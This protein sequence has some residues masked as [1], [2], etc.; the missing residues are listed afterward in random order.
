MEKKIPTALSVDRD[1]KKLTFGKRMEIAGERPNRIKKSFAS[2]RWR[3]ADGKR[4]KSMSDEK[5][6]N[7]FQRKMPRC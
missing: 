4:K 6:L 5:S 1:I 2:F 3:P 7:F